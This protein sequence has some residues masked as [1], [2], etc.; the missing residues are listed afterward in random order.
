MWKAL[1]LS[2]FYLIKAPA[3]L[4][5]YYH[6]CVW[7]FRTR[8]KKIWFTFDDG[9]SPEATPFVLEQLDKFNAK[10][11]F[12]CIGQQVEMHPELFQ[13]II[14]R[15]HTVGNHSFSHLNGWKTDNATYFNDVQKAASLIDSKFFRPPYGRIRKFQIKML[16]GKQLNLK[17]IMWHVISADFDSSISPDQC[18]LNVVRNAKE[19]SIVVFHDSKNAFPNLKEALPKS[20]KYFKEKGYSFEPL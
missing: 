8:E 13:E 19:G 15:G 3:L 9:P 16:Q 10:A 18:Y 6:E 11:T 2:M 1:L 14:Q 5:K 7:K 4:Q 20:L 17:I 12:F